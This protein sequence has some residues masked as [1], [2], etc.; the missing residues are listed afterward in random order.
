MNYVRRVF[1]DALASARPVLA[2]EEV[3]AGWG[4]SSM[5]PEMRVG[6]LAGH[7]LRAATTVT[8][9][10]GQPPQRGKTPIS[11][12]EYFATILTTSDISDPMHVAIR[13]RAEKES[14]QGHDAVVLRWDET[15]GRLTDVLGSEP[16]DRVI[17]VAGDLVMRLDD[18]LVTRLVEVVVHTDDLATSVGLDTPRFAPGAMKLVFDHLVEVARVRHG[19]LA[20]LRGLTRR[21]RDA[22][23]ALR[24]F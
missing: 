11:P 15:M 3:A 2:A 1:L 7:L 17:T 4:N 9:Y 23:N 13:E 22:I 18:Y 21:E 14:A 12:G 16:G 5:L 8:T 19:D 6:A 24:I 10:L 20:V